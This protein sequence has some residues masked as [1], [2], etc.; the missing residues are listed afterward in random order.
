MAM[1]RF[2]ALLTAAVG[3]IG[4]APARAHSCATPVE[5]PV[6]ES[7]TVTVGVAAEQ[8]PLVGVDI[9]LP[10]G[11]RLERAEEEFDWRA[12]RTESLLRY[13]GGSL[14]PYACTYFNLIGQAER[15]AKL[16]FPMTVHG[17]DGSVVEF[18]AEDVNDTH[19]AQL[20]YAGFSAP[21]DGGSRGERLSGATAGMLFAAVVTIGAAALWRRRQT[22]RRPQPQARPAQHK[23]SSVKKSRTKRR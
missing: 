19:P 4:V 3:V 15:Q 8:S 11:F 16:V 12:T 2:L 14:A 17:A 9:S 20:V 13:R 6:G 1:R 5:I 21:S 7:A 23:R 10:A 18:T 22:P